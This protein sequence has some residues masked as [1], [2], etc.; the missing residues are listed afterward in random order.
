MIRCAVP[1]THPGNQDNI[2]IILT[3]FT[4][5]DSIIEAIKSG[6]V[7]RYIKKPWDKDELKITIEMQ[8]KR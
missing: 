8:L 6:K 5:M 4:D 3:G 1:A 7:Y 2:R